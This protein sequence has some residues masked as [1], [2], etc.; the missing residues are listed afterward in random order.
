[1]GAGAGAGAGVVVDVF[2]FFCFLSPSFFFSSEVVDGVDFEWSLLEVAFFLSVVAVTAA[3]PAGGVVDVDFCFLGLSA[4][5]AGKAADSL[6]CL[7]LA[8]SN[9][10][11][12]SG[13]MSESRALVLPMGRN[14]S[15]SPLACVGTRD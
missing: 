1:M 2:S 5:E 14:R 13:N 3:V 7:R 8:R 6:F 4:V 15:R 12:S 9:S 10:I 11:A